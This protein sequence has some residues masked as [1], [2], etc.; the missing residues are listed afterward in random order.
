MRACG[1]T[2]P[3]G[4]LASNGYHASV[5]NIIQI[6]KARHPDVLSIMVLVIWIVAFVVVGLLIWRSKSIVPFEMTDT[7]VVIRQGLVCVKIVLK[8]IH[9][10]TYEDNNYK[11]FG[12]QNKLIKSINEKEYKDISF[13]QKLQQFKS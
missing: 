12:V 2:L 3:V 5:I 8:D 11:F 13:L 10:I 9:R 7:H 6:M 4:S 1:Q